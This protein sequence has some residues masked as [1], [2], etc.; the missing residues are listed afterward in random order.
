MNKINKLAVLLCLTLLV[1]T[2]AAVPSSAASKGNLVKEHKYKTSYTKKGKWTNQGIKYWIT[3]FKYDKHNNVYAIIPKYRRSKGK[4]LEKSYTTKYKLTYKKGKLVKLSEDYG[5]GWFVEE[6]ENGIPVHI[7]YGDLDCDGTKEN[8]YKS[9]YLKFYKDICNDYECDE[10]IITTESFDVQTKD[11]YPVKITSKDN[12][13][14]RLTFYTTGSKKGLIKKAVMKYYKWH[15]D[16]VVEDYRTVYN[17]SYKIKKG[18]VRSYTV[19]A[20]Q[21][22]SSGSIKKGKRTGTFKYTKKKAGSKRYCSMINDI[23]TNFGC[24]GQPFLRTYW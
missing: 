13:K 17:Y 5:D 7:R 11:G 22:Y 8:T 6:Y 2:F 3:K 4:K 21:K 12:D 15:K 23:V 14:T 1:T 9:R 20:V 10:P 16:K 18:L 24:G 19:K